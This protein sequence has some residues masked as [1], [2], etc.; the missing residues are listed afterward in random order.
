MGNP[1]HAVMY[2]DRERTNERT[3]TRLLGDTRHTTH[4]TRH[5]RPGPYVTLSLCAHTLP[6]KRTRD[7]PRAGTV[8][9]VNFLTPYSSN[10][11]LRITSAGFHLGRPRPHGAVRAR[12]L[13][14]ASAAPSAGSQPGQ[15][16]GAG[17]PRRVSSP[18]IFALR[19]TVT[20]QRVE[21]DG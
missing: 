19:A 9:S 1:A 6:K 17:A 18:E 8:D 2:G 13:G 12:W 4:F 5:R 3:N 15:P 20:Y 21:A 7:A 11:H 16:A 10:V 14:D